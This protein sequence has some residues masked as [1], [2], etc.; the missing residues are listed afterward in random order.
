VRRGSSG[1]GLG[2]KKE[3][4]RIVIV[5]AGNAGRNL[6]KKLCGMGH[7]VVVIDHDAETLANLA[8]EIDA[9]TVEGNGASPSVLDRA[10][11][12]KADLLAA[13]TS[14]D[15][16]NILACVCARRAGKAHTIARISEASYLASPLLD[17]KELGVDHALSHKVECAREI[18]NVFQLP[19]T[20]EA[21]QLLGGRITAL[22]L[23]LPDASP[24]LGR[25]LM[26]FGEEKWF[27][28]VRFIAL[29]HDGKL[30]IPGGESQFYAGDDVYVVLA[31][32]DT[33]RFLD[34]TLNSQRSGFKKVII[35]GGGELGLSLAKLLEKTST[36]VV[37]VDR[38]RNRAENASAQL[39]KCLVIHADVTEAATLKDIGVDAKTAFA[40]TTE[41]EEL[42][43]V[44]CIQAKQLGA[45]FTVARIDK[46]EYVPIIDTLK[47]LDRVVSPYISMVKVILQFVR[48]ENVMDVGLFHRISGELQEMVIRPGSR[49]VGKPLSALKLLP[50][51]IVAAV[52]RD[53]TVSVPTGD[54]TL[55]END[56]LALYCLPETADRLKSVF[57]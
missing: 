33:S 29:V 35:A 19:G 36:E 48:G 4:M 16:V 9:M 37:L 28:R 11:I 18:F 41:D 2:G 50:N 25:R 1:K 47:L 31:P 39:H 15:E 57:T 14:R 7:D 27:D 26:E 51:A 44:S 20:L 32:G 49:A 22:G 24:L 38:N 5:G 8:S 54:F 56:R 40:S 30:E 17:L 42:N 21:A 46:P 43:M 10:E 13:V 45:G 12:A 3:A 34:W 6:V 23:K 52:E 55:R 53:N